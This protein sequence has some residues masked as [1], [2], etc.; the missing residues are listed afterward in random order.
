LLGAGFTGVRV[1]D[2]TANVRPSLRRLY[3]LTTLLY[4]GEGL[5]R[6]LRLRSAVQHGNAVGARTQW[7]ALQRGLWLYGLVTARV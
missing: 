1:N 7:T 4:P 2:I 5:L 6:G 3:T